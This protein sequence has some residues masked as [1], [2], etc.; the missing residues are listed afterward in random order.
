MVLLV[1]LADYQLRLRKVV[2]LAFVV[3]YS[4]EPMVLLVRKALRPDRLDR[5]VPWMV[6]VVLGS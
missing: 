1:L 6:D 4:V 3:E 2:D 5:L